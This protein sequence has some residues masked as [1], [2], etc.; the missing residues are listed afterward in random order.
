[1]QIRHV[2]GIHQD[3]V[4]VKAHE[5]AGVNGQGGHP[6][7]SRQHKGSRLQTT[8]GQQGPSKRG[9]HGDHQLRS[10]AGTRHTQTLEPVRQA[11][12]FIGVGVGHRPHDKKGHAHG[13]HTA[14]VMLG[15]ECVPKL[16]QQLHKNQGHPVSQQAFE[17]E[18]VDQRGT[19]HVPTPHH[20]RQTQHK[21]ERCDPGKG[22]ASELARHRQP[23]GEPGI[24]PEQGDPEKQVMVQQPIERCALHAG[25]LL[26]QLARC[27]WRRCQHQLM[28]HQELRYTKYIFGLH[29]HCG[30]ARDIG[31]DQSRIVQVP[32][33]Q[34]FQ[35]GPIDAKEL[36][37]DRIVQC[38]TGLTI[39]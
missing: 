31:C 24:W 22:P 10:D 8:R 38:P 5:R 17:V 11:P 9:P 25:P 15:G 13:G 2:Q 30:L 6:A 37:S 36:V 16:V 3:E 20:L 27:I 34:N 28:L 33:S 26:C 29:G 18:G 39:G 32:A 23:A 7:G 1:M 21:S 14:T 12:S 19:E 4:A 35:R